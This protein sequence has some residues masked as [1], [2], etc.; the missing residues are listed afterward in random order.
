[1]IAILTQKVNENRWKLQHIAH[2]AVHGVELLHHV[3]DDLGG[4]FHVVDAA[5]HLA[6][7]DLGGLGVVLLG[8]GALVTVPRMRG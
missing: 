1:M 8:R 7:G 2:T 6:H 5:Q 3:L 4:G